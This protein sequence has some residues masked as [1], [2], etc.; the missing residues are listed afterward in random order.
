MAGCQ[1][2]VMQRCL[3]PIKGRYGGGRV[4]S[5]IHDMP[6]LDFVRECA[7]WT[8]ALLAH[9]VD[10]VRPESPVFLSVD[11]DVLTALGR[12]R[13]R[14]V[15]DFLALIRRRWVRR[16]QRRD[17]PARVEV[18]LEPSRL[19]R[20]GDWR[21]Y[22]TF[23]AAMVLAAHWMEK[24]AVEGQG[25]ARLKLVIDETNYFQRL[26]QVLGLEWEKESGRPRGLKEYEEKRVWDWWNEWVKAQGR[27]PTARPG[28]KGS[29]HRYISYPLSQ[30]MLRDCDRQRL[31]EWF[32]R[33]AQGDP[34][35][36]TLDRDTLL[37]WMLAHQH[38]LH[39]PRL[40]QIL[41]RP[42]DRVRF[43][44][45]AD[46]AFELYSAVDWDEEPAVDHTGTTS[47]PVR[48]VSAGLHREEDPFTGQV[49]YSLYPRQP[50]QAVEFVLTVTFAGVEI[51]LRP[52]RPGWFG[53]LP[54]GP[55]PPPS[56]LTMQV[57]GH[58]SL[59]E[60]TFPDRDFW[61]LAGDP[62][63]AGGGPFATWD[64]PMLERP[65]M[66]LC[67]PTY[68]AL[69]EKLREQRLL[70]W[71]ESPYE[72]SAGRWLEYRGCRRCS[73]DW[74][75]RLGE[76]DSSEQ[77]LLRILRPRVSGTIEFQD[78][79]QAPDRGDGW[80]QDYLPRILVSALAGTALVTVNNLQSQRC[81][82]TQAVLANEPLD[83][84]VLEPGYYRIDAAL[85]D[86]ETDQSPEKTLSPRILT[87]RAWESLAC[88]A[89]LDQEV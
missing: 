86:G 13:G 82:L 33:E 83:L 67:R 87:V 4:A 71:H 10:S 39:L 76:F 23:L 81:E 22:V 15:D 77:A 44:A 63:T 84:P 85:V 56:A 9:F 16:I 14:S 80:M 68:R 12:K 58:P 73:S 51:R 36:R 3:W 62:R 75:L 52:D 74:R 17:Q 53:P 27:Q 34:G 66:L 30:T 11:D 20:A 48:R 78:G 60:L 6:E 79:L 89:V 40:W 19:K 37:G 57:G 61:I 64:S 26:R 28:K 38:R 46:A 24:E 55:S 88:A 45:T 5:V 35:V 72:L 1:S 42:Q 31:A 32:W 65:F 7:S 29:P 59:R 70:D 2:G 25:E 43:D 47:R 54:W 50:A 41:E 18:V 8:E 49:L 69:L 21:E